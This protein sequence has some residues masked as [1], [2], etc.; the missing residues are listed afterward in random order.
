MSHRF[1]VFFEK[2]MEFESPTNLSFGPEVVYSHGIYCIFMAY[3]VMPYIVMANIV[4]T[5]IV[6]AYIIMVYL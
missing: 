6:M 3:T 1:V 2:E 4:M 5:Y